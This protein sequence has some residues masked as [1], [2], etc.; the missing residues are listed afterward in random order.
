MTIPNTT[1]IW[2]INNVV[3]VTALSSRVFPPS[4]SERCRATQRISYRVT[5]MQCAILSSFVA[6]AWQRLGSRSSD[7][8]R[9]GMPIFITR[10]ALERLL[11]GSFGPRRLTRLTIGNALCGLIVCLA[12]GFDVRGEVG[13]KVEPLGLA[14]VLCAHSRPPEARSYTRISRAMRSIYI[15][16]S[17][18][19]LDGR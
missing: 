4:A 6:L 18:R 1:R 3:G 8:S 13:L 9:E 19:V 10:M 5:S 17:C 12:S 11:L 7:P 14:F 15:F 2:P 16:L